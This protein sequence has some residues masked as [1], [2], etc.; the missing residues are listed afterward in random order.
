MDRITIIGLGPIGISIGL[1]LKN[2]GIRN[3]EVVGS[4]ANKQT[5]K[6]V[7]EMGAFDLVTGNLSQALEDAQLVVIDT[8]LDETRELLQAIGPTLQRDTVVTETGTA[9]LKV[10]EWANEYLPRGVEIIGSR[11]LP[12]R[13]VSK[14][15]DADPELFKNSTF[16]IVSPATASGKSIQTVAGLA[17]VLGAKPLFMDPHEY[18]SYVTAVT[19][20]PL[21]VASAAVLAATDREAWG[22][23]M[24]MLA[25]NEF[26]DISRL[27]SYDPQDV[28]TAC[29]ATGDLLV[30]WIDEMIGQLNSFKQL[31]DPKEQDESDGQEE[32]DGLVDAFIDAWEQRAKWRMGGVGQPTGAPKAMS[33]TQTMTRMFVGGRAAE[34]IARSENSEDKSA[35]W[36]YRPRK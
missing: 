33:A 3:T 19:H 13:Q 35:P 34:R 18:D 32:G 15:E 1:A 29:H 17:E 9:K 22:Q 5:L 6:Q 2:S 7:H 14:P 12:R 11:P 30:Y 26:Y 8:P 4:D 27:A 36:K 23:E 24:H 20:L 28:A 25:S 31:V 16:C 21:V 10:F